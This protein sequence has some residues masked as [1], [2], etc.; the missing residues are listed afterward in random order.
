MQLA[1]GASDGTI[2]VWELGKT[3]PLPP[4]PPP[5]A[6]PPHSPCLTSFVHIGPCAAGTLQDEEDGEG[7]GE[8]GQG[9]TTTTTPKTLTPKLRVLRRLLSPRSVRHTPIAAAVKALQFAPSS[10]AMTSHS[11]SY[12]SSSGDGNNGQGSIHGYCKH[13]KQIYLCRKKKKT[14]WTTFD[15]HLCRHSP[16]SPPLPPPP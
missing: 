15:L 5:L 12:S 3:P 13:N 9:T 11:S 8:R 4:P 1:V 16:I 14:S 10:S 7:A 6:Q 2:T